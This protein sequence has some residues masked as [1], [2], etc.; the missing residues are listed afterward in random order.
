MDETIFVINKMDEVANLTD[1]E[2]FREQEIIKKKVVNDRLLSIPNISNSIEENLNIVCISANPNGRGLDFWFNKEDAYV[3]RSRIDNLNLV[4]EEILKN[5][6]MVKLINKTGVDVILDICEEVTKDLKSELKQYDEYI[7]TTE[8]EIE[9]IR[10]EMYVAERKIK[11]S[12]SDF[13]TSLNNMQNRMLFKIKDIS[14]E[15]ILTFI[16]E[17]IGRNN[18]ELG[19]KLRLKIE[20]E[21]DKFFNQSSAILE[22]VSRSIES[23]IESSER[24]LNDIVSASLG[25]SGKIF[26]QISKI[27]EG[28]I[29]EGLFK[30]RDIMEKVF[31]KKIKFKPWGATKWSKRIAKYSG[32]IGMGVEMLMDFINLSQKSKAERQLLEVKRDLTDF[33]NEYFGVVYDTIGDDEKFIEAY[34]PQLLEFKKIIENQQ[35]ILNGLQ[36]KQHYLSAIDTKLIAMKN[37]LQ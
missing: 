3:K 17:E 15:E 5:T 9:R 33:V 36:N 35:D 2:E 22:H 27:D 8:N 6:S 13:F 18:D 20:F 14:S 4:V 10:H 28:K 23:H 7:E 25:K 31:K 37:E 19:Q 24:L 32:P 12:K 1:I 29:K 16:D 30:A 11:D 34:A 26:K 21:S